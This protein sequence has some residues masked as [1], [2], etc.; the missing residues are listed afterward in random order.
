MVEGESELTQLRIDDSRKKNTGISCGKAIS[1]Q[2]RTAVK[3]GPF[4]LS[5]CVTYPSTEKTSRLALCRY[6][7]KHIIPSR[8]ILWG[9]DFVGWGGVNDAVRL[10]GA[11]ANAPTRIGAKP[12]LLRRSFS[13]NAIRQLPCSSFPDR[14]RCA[15]LRSGGAALRDYSRSRPQTVSV[16]SATRKFTLKPPKLSP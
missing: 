16:W 6:F 2:R 8:D 9:A 13:K 5:C 3:C 1:Q 15:G 4:F 12:A 14:T 11:K 10:S 7:S